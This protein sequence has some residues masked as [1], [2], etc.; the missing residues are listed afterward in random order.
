[1]SSNSLIN[2]RPDIPLP[3]NIGSIADWKSHSQFGSPCSRVT[4]TELRKHSLYSTEHGGVGDPRRTWTENGWG[5][6]IVN[7]DVRSR[8]HNVVLSIKLLPLL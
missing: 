2:T 4:F 6:V 5:R 1:M 3:L 7:I 8:L